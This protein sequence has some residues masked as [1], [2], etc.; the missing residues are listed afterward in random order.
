MYTIYM[1][2]G[3]MGTRSCLASGIHEKGRKVILEVILLG[4]MLMGLRGCLGKNLPAIFV[5]GDSLV[6]VGNNNYIASLTKSNFVPF[7]IDFG[8]ATGR[9]TN[10]RTIPDIIGQE[11]GFNE[12]IPP[13]MD[14]TTTGSRILS[15]V[16][17]ASAGGGILNVSGA[18]YGVRINMDAQLGC[19]ENTR[20]EIISLI[21]EAAALDLLKNSL[22]AVTMGSNDFITYY[23]NPIVQDKTQSPDMFADA[24]IS[25]FRIQLTRLHNLGARKIVVPNVGPIGCVPYEIDS[26]PSAGDDCATFPNQA[27]EAFNVRLRPLI[28]ELNRSL[29]GAIFVYADIYTVFLDVITNYQSYG[30]EKKNAACCHLAGLHGGLIPCNPASSVC[31]DRSKYVFWDPFHPTDATNFIISSRLIGGD[32]SIISPMNIRQLVRS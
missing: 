29:K 2:G 13:Y 3:S 26:N 25:R 30:F 20:R 10:N 17:Y 32:P 4:W 22:F 9:F 5:F 14:P 1:L 7:G 19:F 24:M 18:V 8:R 27:A 11:L 15:G 16:N 12:F 28:R 31:E 23:L 21:G 6:D